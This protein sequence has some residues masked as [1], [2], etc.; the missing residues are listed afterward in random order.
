MQIVI[1]IMQIV[2]N[3]I[4]QIVTPIYRHDSSYLTLV[5]ITGMMEN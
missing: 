4:M 5:R 3:I 1:N 2:I